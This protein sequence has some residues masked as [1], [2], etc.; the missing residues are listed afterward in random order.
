MKIAVMSDSHDHIEHLEKAVDLI[1]ASG[2]EI[3]VHCGDLCSPFM[4]ERLA[5]FPGH[6]HIVFGNNDG[7]RFTIGRIAGRYPNVTVHGETGEIE[8]NDGTIAFT[9]R[10]EFGEGLAATGRYRAVFSGHTHRNKTED[11]EGAIHINPGEVMGLVEDPGF[12]IFDTGSG[13]VEHVIIDE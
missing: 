7:D 2:A 9:H 1:K 6:V 3:L 13:G 10:P 8:T 12:A 4:I 11:V 5:A